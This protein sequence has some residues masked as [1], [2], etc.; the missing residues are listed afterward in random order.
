MRRV[1]PTLRVVNSLVPVTTRGERLREYLISQVGSRRGW[2]SEL[3]ARTG[4][5]RQT[6]TKWTNR[7]FD[8][9]PDMETVVTVAEGIGVRP[10]EIVAAMEGD[11][12][13]VGPAA[14]AAIRRVVEAALDERLGPPGGNPG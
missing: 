2:Q 1:R 12:P 5:K 14:E 13:P 10:W 6:F 3:V 4:V 7:R 9:Y 8:G 11:A